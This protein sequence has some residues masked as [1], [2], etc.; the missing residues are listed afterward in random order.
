MVIAEKELWIIF[1]EII[2]FNHYLKILL[3]IL[4]ILY[5]IKIEK[6]FLKNKINL[7]II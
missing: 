5:Y 7:K 1:F 6:V 4:N 3:L 2:L